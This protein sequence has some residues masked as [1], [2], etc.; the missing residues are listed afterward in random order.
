M[1]ITSLEIPAVHLIELSRR[2]DDRGFFARLSCQ[3]ELAAVGLKGNWL[4]INNSFTA[5]KGVLRGIHF[6]RP[7][8]AEVK[9]VRCIKGAIFD[10]AVDLRD[11]SKTFGKWVARTLTSENRKMLYIPEGFGHGFQ[12]L[13][14]GSEI[15]YLNTA[16]YDPE[17]EGGVRYDDSEIRVAWPEPIAF[18]SERDKNLPSLSSLQPIKIA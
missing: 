11:G 1:K 16:N 13:E 17:R 12:S 15:I 4:Q 5:E 18:T 14:R 8:S 9:M 6:Q 2:E 7:P 10:V 3:T